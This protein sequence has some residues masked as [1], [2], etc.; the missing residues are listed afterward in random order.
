MRKETRIRS[1]TRVMSF[2]LPPV[3][4]NPTRVYIYFTDL[5]VKTRR[6]FA[7]LFTIPSRKYSYLCLYFYEIKECPRVGIFVN[8]FIPSA[9]LLFPVII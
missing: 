9:G 8:I 6:D 4:A 1:D 2:S 5:L 3:V 7:D